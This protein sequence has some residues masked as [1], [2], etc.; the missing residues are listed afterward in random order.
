MIAFLHPAFTIVA[1]ILIIYTF[2][3]VYN[4]KKYS[5]LAVV[6][7]I[8]VLLLGFRLAGADYTIYADMY[9]Y[10][11]NN[12]SYE[13]VWIKARFG[14]ANLDIEWIY[15]LLGKIMHDA[16]LPFF[17]FTFV[18]AFFAIFIKF[19]SFRTNVAYPSLALLLYMF[20]TYFAA[21][22]GHMR[23]GMAMT[24]SILSI[25]FIKKRQLLGFLLIMYFALG[26]HNSAITFIPAYWIA[27]FPLNSTR[28]LLIVLGCIVLS[29]FKIYEYISLLDS[30]QEADIYKG[31]NSYTQTENVNAGRVS[32]TDL[33]CIM[34]LYYLI[35]YNKEAC[36][37]IP[38]YEYFRNLAFTGICLYFIFRSNGAFST[39][40]TAHYFTIMI[41]V[42]PNIIAAMEN[43]KTKRFLHLAVVSFA[44]FYY[45]VYAK[46]QAPG[47]TYDMNYNNYLFFWR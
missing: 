26:F 35:T 30:L 31:F 3:E 12:V 42:Y 14:E 38:Y 27:R 46:M 15:V 18:L 2:L 6:A 17:I 28:M 22:G 39:R 5:S 23:Q 9:N 1:I 41:M 8:M 20:P 32:F 29:P 25:Y 40:L 13:M 19:F 45:F 10:M 11:A 36:S 43:I 16:N 34:N 7:F 37:K 24:L 21:D 33:I 44:I 47:V 4:D